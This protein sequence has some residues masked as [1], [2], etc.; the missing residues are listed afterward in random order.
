MI[1]QFGRFVDGTRNLLADMYILDPQTR[2]PYMPGFGVLGAPQQVG[3]Q[4]IL[5]S[6][7]GPASTRQNNQVP[8]PQGQNQNANAMVPMPRPNYNPQP[9]APILN[10]TNLNPNTGGILQVQPQLSRRDAAGLN[11]SGSMRQPVGVNP[12][13]NRNEILMRMAGA[14]LEAVDKGGAAQLGAALSAYGTAMDEAR[15]VLGSIPKATASKEME[16]VE[17][18]NRY[19]QS[20]IEMDTVLDRLRSG[21]NV[22]GMFGGGDIFAFKDKLFG[23]DP[24]NA[25]RNTTRLMMS[26]LK[27]D[28]ILISTAQTK[29]AISDR[30]MA[31]FAEPVPTLQDEERTWI[32]WIEQRRDLLKTIRKRLA[33]G[34]R[35][36]NPARYIPD[37]ITPPDSYQVDDNTNALIQRYTQ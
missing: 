34:I 7:M 31:L 23:N 22:S 6:Q 29:G 10:N 27:V 9:V 12:M 19:D 8:N 17:N 21:D 14:G 2:L 25:R 11:T 13:M 36:N 35:V 15:D 32:N 24:D 3:T 4:P 5:A 1:D 28:N 16:M 33:N 18:L 37:T 30:E 26:K 20:I